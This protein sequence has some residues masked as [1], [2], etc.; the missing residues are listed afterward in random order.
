MSLRTVIIHGDHAISCTPSVA[1][2][3][4]AAAAVAPADAVATAE[5]V[6]TSI[7]VLADLTLATSFTQAANA[8]KAANEAEFRWA[9][10]LLQLTNPGEL[11]QGFS[12]PGPAHDERLPQFWSTWFW[13]QHFSRMKGGQGAL[14]FRPTLFA[15]N[16]ESKRVNL[17]RITFGGRN[18]PLSNFEDAREAAW[19]FANI[20]QRGSLPTLEAAN[21]EQERKEQR[22]REQQE[23][24]RERD[25][26]REAAA[27]L[28]MQ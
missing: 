19:D 23:Q 10:E 24:Q 22:E 14:V 4:A 12:R 9:T 27:K 21:E 25:Q 17:Y 26:Q 6:V 15:A 13:S 1:L 28:H 3:A 7:F 16:G 11:A 20:H 8:A 5:V 2:A 18:D